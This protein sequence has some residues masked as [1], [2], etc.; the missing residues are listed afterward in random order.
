MDIIYCDYVFVTVPLIHPPSKY[1]QNMMTMFITG[2]KGKIS[3]HGFHGNKDTTFWQQQN[4]ISVKSAG[5]KLLQ[6]VLVNTFQELTK[7]KRFRIQFENHRKI[8]H[9]GQTLTSGN[10][11]LQTMLKS[12][13]LMTMIITK[14]VKNL[15]R[16]WAQKN[17]NKL[18]P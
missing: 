11:Y 12:Q 10:A 9:H 15:L 18:C 3:C 13:V 6:Q 8:I 16:Y 14:S 1:R 17:D 4:F 7:R 5:C 2:K